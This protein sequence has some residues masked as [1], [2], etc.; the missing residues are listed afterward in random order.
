MSRV[1]QLR[2]PAVIVALAA[3]LVLFVGGA[4][5]VGRAFPDSNQTTPTSTPRPTQT[6]SAA[7]DLFLGFVR[8]R[9]PSLASASD[10]ILESTGSA[11]CGVFEDGGSLSDVYAQI[12]ATS[13]FTTL[14]LAELVAVGVQSYCPQYLNKLTP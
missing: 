14:E 5:T 10:G 3:L 11:A 8:S 9:Y 4:L 7:N 6:D 12:P 2:A 1:R 13:P